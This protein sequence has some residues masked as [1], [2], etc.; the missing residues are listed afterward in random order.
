MQN[1]QVVAYVSRQLKTYERNYPTHDLEL[2]IIVFVIKMWRCHTLISS[3]DHY[4]LACD[5]HLTTS[6]CLTP[7]AV[8][9]VKFRYVSGRN[10][11]KTRK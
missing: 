8:E 6:K 2:T 3:E 1:G 9:S 7:I 11:S 4:L 10:R 5:L